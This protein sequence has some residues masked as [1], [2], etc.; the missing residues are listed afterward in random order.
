VGGVAMAQCF[1][2][3]G[4]V[5][6]VLCDTGRGVRAASASNYPEIRT[7]L[8]AVKLALLPHVSGAFS[9]GP[10]HASVNA[11]LGLFFSQK[12]SRHRPPAVTWRSAPP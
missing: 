11:G 2:D 12:D 9:G 4:T 8:E 1:P 6:I 3:R 10:Y 7:D 5:R